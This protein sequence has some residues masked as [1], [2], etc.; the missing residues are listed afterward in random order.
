V[1]IRCFYSC[2]AC[3][4][5][6]Q[7][8]EVPERDPVAQDVVQWIRDTAV[9]LLVADHESKSPLC[10]PEEFAEVG[11]PVNDATEHVGVKSYE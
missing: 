2:A 11:I 1:T 9:P 10:R 7:F 8:V 6:R 5:V 3:M 4:L